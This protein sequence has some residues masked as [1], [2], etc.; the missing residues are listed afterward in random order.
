[1]NHLIVGPD[2][3]HCFQGSILLVMYLI[4]LELEGKLVHVSWRV[5]KF[6]R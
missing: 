3:S 6:R 5:G 1:M 2:E 4:F